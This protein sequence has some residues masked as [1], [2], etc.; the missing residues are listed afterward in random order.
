MISLPISLAKLVNGFTQPC[1]E[2]WLRGSSRCQLS[3]VPICDGKLCDQGAANRR[4]SPANSCLLLRAAPIA[5]TP[6]IPLLA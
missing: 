3:I 6:N 4:L 2:P 1:P 5:S